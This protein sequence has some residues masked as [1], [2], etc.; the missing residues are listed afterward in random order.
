MLGAQYASA[1]QRPISL[2]WSKNV[3]CPIATIS[4]TCSNRKEQDKEGSY[5]TKNWLYLDAFKAQ[6]WSTHHRWSLSIILC[7][8][9][10]LITDSNNALYS[11]KKFSSTVQR[12]IIK[13]LFLIFNKHSVF[14][15]LL[16]TW[17]ESQ[18]GSHRASLTAQVEVKT[19]GNPC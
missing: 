17:R 18:E 3:L 2:K 4:K 7:L 6:Y 11:L 1:R 16:L 9:I 10:L 19:F 12:R 8:L 5:A 15:R 14:K 13:L